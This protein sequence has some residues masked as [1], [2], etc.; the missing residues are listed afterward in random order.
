M[1]PMT[2]RVPE[3]FAAWL[4]DRAARETI[5]RRQRY[6]VNNLIVDLI[7]KEMEAEKKG[8]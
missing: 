6:S 8:E 1:K 3:E 5:K 2:V 4:T 7:R